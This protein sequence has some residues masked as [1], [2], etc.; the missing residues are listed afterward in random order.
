MCIFELTQEM[1]PL[2]QEFQHYMKNKF[3]GDI[4]DDFDE[5]CASYEF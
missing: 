2:R 1:L 5:E 3:P 4:L